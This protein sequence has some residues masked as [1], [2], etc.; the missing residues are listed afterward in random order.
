MG[1]EIRR[2]PGDWQH[3]RYTTEDAP[4]PQLIG[5]YKALYD[6]D[7]ESAA[8]E[9]MDN[10]ALWQAGKHPDQCESCKYY[11]QWA[12]GPPDEDSYR[13]RKWT[14]EEATHYQMY[15]TV[16][17]GTPVTPVF[18]KLEHLRDHLAAHGTEWDNGP[19]PIDAAQRFIENQWAPSMI[20]VGGQVKQVNESGFY[21]EK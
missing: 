20:V 8:I 19:W 10:L 6:N 17:E 2:V 14:E 21:P 13:E 16:S 11:W 18:A 9:W 7:L 12:G 3:P 15:E 5:K 4:R 1:R